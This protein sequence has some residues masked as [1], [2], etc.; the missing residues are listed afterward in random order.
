M[1]RMAA[2]AVFGAMAL[3]ATAAAAQREPRSDEAMAW[4]RSLDTNGWTRS[5]LSADE[6]T[7]T[8]RRA[9]ETKPDGLVTMWERYERRDDY[10]GEWR[11]LVALS[12]YD[13]QEKRARTLQ[14]TTYSE[15][16]L[17]G[18]ASTAAMPGDWTYPIPGSMME[19]SMRVACEPP[20]TKARAA[21]TAAETKAAPAAATE[22]AKPAPAAG[23]AKAKAKP[24]TA[25][26]K[27]TAA[28]AKAPAKKPVATKKKTSAKRKPPAEPAEKFVPIPPAPPPLDNP[29]T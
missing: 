24:K 9:P 28:T 2:L 18:R 29:P 8:F 1:R 12:E 17:G 23:A 15:P 6:R 27:T 14:E 13:C 5:G 11:S 21:A 10:P 22:K 26:T 25:A 4:L 20:R 19:S 16:N 7:V 3:G